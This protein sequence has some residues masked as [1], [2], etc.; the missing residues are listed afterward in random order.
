MSEA[1]SSKLTRVA[2]I[3]AGIFA[4]EAHLPALL[5]LNERIQVVAI[6]S[7]SAASATR[8]AK[9]AGP[10]VEASSDLD[11]LLA[12]DD[13]DAMDIVLPIPDQAAIVAHA[14]ATGK[15]VVS[16]KPIAPDLATAGALLGLHQERPGQV[17]M[18]AE[19]WRYEEA[20]LQAGELVRA[21]AIGRP[22]ACQLGV[23]VAMDPANKYFQ[24]AWRR[25]GA[26][27]GGFLLDGGVHYAAALRQVVGEIAAVSAVTAQVSPALPP[28]DTLAATLH[29]ENGV[30]GTYMTTFAG[31]SPWATPLTVV[32]DAGSLRVERGKVELS[33]A[34]GVVQTLDFGAQHGVERELAAFAAAV[35]SGAVMR[36]TPEEGLRDLAVIEAMLHAAE[37]GRTEQ[38][39]SA[40]RNATRH[41]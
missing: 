21:G 25:N 18:V 36:N 16:E 27:P 9:A 13:I 8:L 20:F 23:F 19:N 35:Q 10:M 7:R 33:D 12:R 11:G 1:S 31:S 14:L 5:R 6:W 41:P 28:A 2:M 37:T 4:R 29:F 26:F 30:V 39:T 3:G 40:G 24:T 22:V 17:W 15:H 32:G 38:V 34:A